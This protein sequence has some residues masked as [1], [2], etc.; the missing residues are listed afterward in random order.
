MKKETTQHWVTSGNKLIT[1]VRRDL[2]PSYALV[3]SIHS[4]IDF[5]LKNPHIAKDWHINSNSII[6]LSTT[7]EASLNDICQKLQ[8]KQIKFT[9]FFEPDINQWTS[10]CLEPTLAARKFT[11]SFPLALKELNSAGI[12]KHTFTKI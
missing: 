11:S 4:A 3:Q 7:D 6:S 9:A 5:V 1:I 10:I 12:T 2:S 8:D